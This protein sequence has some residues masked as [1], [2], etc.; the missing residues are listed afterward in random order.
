MRLKRRDDFLRT[1]REGVGWKG[2]CFSL[3]I[4]ASD[5]GPRLGIVI[6]RRYGNAVERNRAKRRIREAYRRIAAELPA[7]DVIVR[8]QSACLRLGIDELGRALVDAV[9]EALAKGGKK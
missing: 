6:S 5:A 3:Q 2:V 9:H 8:P 7:V 1:T 4:A